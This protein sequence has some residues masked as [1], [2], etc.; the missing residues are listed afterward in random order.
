MRSFGK[1]STLLVL[2]TAVT[3]SI[4]NGQ[5]PASWERQ[6]GTTADDQARAVAMD[7]TGVYIAG[8]TTGA[9]VGNNA[10]GDDGFVRKYDFAGK[11]LWTSQIGTAGDDCAYAIAV[12]G[13]GVYVS[14]WTY[15]VLDGSHA[16]N[17]NG[18]AFVRKYDTTGKILWTRQ[19]GT[20]AED[21]ANAIAVDATGVY[22]VGNTLG[23]L[24]GPNVGRW[25]AFVRKYDL[26]GNVVW[27]NQFG[28]DT[29]DFANGIVVDATGIY[30]TGFTIGTLSGQ[31]A[32]WW[33]AFVRKYDANGNVAWTKQ[34]GSAG[35]DY[36]NAIAA[37]ATGI[38][39][40]GYTTGSLFGN[41]A[42]GWDA[43]VW[44]CDPNGNV[45][46]ADQFGTAYDDFAWAIATDADGI[47]VAGWTGGTLSGNSAGGVDAFLRRYTTNGT[48]IETTQFGSSGNDQITGI[49]IFQPPNGSQVRV[50]AGY[51]SGNMVGQ[52][53]GG[54]DVFT[55]FYSVP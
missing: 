25:D 35:A 40:V 26:N 32:G 44:K 9:L 15:G 16:V 39:V 30:V 13:S 51:T 18:D 12:D 54:M 49:A 34:F 22:V 11:V 2:I 52:N 46:W 27:T 20:T 4:A 41:N 31:S 47:Q 19:F 36:T 17:A 21:Y 7:A 45:L 14:G 37:D 55:G 29:D 1:L 10:G 28:T 50:L 3:I 43:W 24:G 33:D 53:A 38:Y 6:F 5:N 48:V 23:S 8:D 42:G